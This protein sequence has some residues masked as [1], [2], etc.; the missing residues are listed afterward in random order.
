MPWWWNGRHIS[1]VFGINRYMKDINDYINLPKSER[2]QHLKLDEACIE[3]GA[4]SYYFKGLLAHILDTTVPKGPKIHLCHACHNGACGNP[5][6]MYWGTPKENR[7]DQVENGTSDSPWN[8][9]VA[10]YGLDEARKMNAT[11]REGNKNGSGNKGKPKS[12]E[13]KRNIAL[14]HKGGRPKKNASVV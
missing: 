14:N 11:G 12:E 8:R 9:M 10:K 13:H 3:R 7:L 4:G 6:H 2:Q 5:N 1:Y